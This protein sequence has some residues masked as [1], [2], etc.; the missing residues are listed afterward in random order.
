MHRALTIVPWTKHLPGTSTIEHWVLRWNLSSASFPL[1][2]CHNQWLVAGKAIP[3][4]NPEVKVPRGCEWADEH[5]I[6]KAQATSPS[7]TWQV[8]TWGLWYPPQKWGSNDPFYAECAPHSWSLPIWNKVCPRCAV[9]RNHSST[10]WEGC[11]L[12]M[13]WRWAWSQKYMTHR[14]KHKVSQVQQGCLQKLNSE[15]NH[16]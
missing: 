10:A 12:C 6:V 15:L 16:L 7:W 4:E 1:Q 13:C 11:F 8:S 9:S 14:S 2:D 3:Y 5:V